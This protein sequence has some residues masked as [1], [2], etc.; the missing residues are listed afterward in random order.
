MWLNTSL[1][2]ICSNISGAT[3]DKGNEL[4]ESSLEKQA[5]HNVLFQRIGF[6]KY[7]VKFQETPSISIY[8]VPSSSPEV[9]SQDT[10]CSEPNIVAFA[11]LLKYLCEI[12]EVSNA[13]ALISLTFYISSLMILKWLYSP[14]GTFLPVARHHHLGRCLMFSAVTGINFSLLG[15]EFS[16]LTWLACFVLQGPHQSVALLLCLNYLFLEEK[17][18]YCSSLDPT[19]AAVEI[20]ACLFLFRKN[21]LLWLFGIRNMIWECF[22]RSTCFF[23]FFF[24]C[25]FS[26]IQGEIKTSSVMWSCYFCRWQRKDFFR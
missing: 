21:T 17:M 6:V 5:V 24:S 12:T 20:P 10:L 2:D 22:L 3:E 1:C 9:L 19:V 16:L 15:A 8:V 23:F 7:S 11:R 25:G 14:E 13:C 4:M 18:A 26:Q